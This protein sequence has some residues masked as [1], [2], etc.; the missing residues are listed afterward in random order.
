MGGWS[1]DW[2][3][4]NGFLDELVN[5]NTIA[6]TGNTNISELNDPVINNLFAK[7]NT[8]TGAARTAIWSQIDMQVMKDAAVLPGVYAK[9]AGLPLAEHDQRLHMGPVRHVQLRGAGREVLT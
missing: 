2:P 5:G 3:N 7:S 6:P 4:G 8:L 9:V 1:A